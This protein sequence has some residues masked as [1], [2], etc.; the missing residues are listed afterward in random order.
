MADKTATQPLSR[1][2]DA[3]FLLAGTN[4]LISPAANNLIRLYAKALKRSLML[5]PS[6]TW[7]YR[8]ALSLSWIRPA[9]DTA[10]WQCGC[11]QRSFFMQVTQDL[12]LAPLD[13]KK[14]LEFNSPHIQGFCHSSLEHKLPS[15]LLPWDGKCSLNRNIGQLNL[16]ARIQRLVLK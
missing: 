14:T 1:P 16:A 8:R 10:R 12:I 4:M 11:L 5:V 15:S 2:E 6:A 3:T 13:M 7:S 9:Q